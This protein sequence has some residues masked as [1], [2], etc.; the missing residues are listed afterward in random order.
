MSASSLIGSNLSLGS[1]SVQSLTATALTVDGTKV[2]PI[3][4]SG[5]CLFEGDNASTSWWIPLGLPANTLDKSAPVLCGLQI[6]DGFTGNSVVYAQPFSSATA[7]YILV[8]FASPVVNNVSVAFAVM[9]T[10]S[11]ELTGTNTEPT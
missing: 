4:M 8:E 9:T 11:T 3:F 5:T 1:L 10:S 6:Q 7:Q 2:V